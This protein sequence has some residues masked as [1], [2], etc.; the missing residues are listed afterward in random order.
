MSYTKRERE[1][2]EFAT[3]KLNENI[4]SLE[5]VR[6]TLEL[7]HNCASDVTGIVPTGKLLS[8]KLADT[9]TALEDVEVLFRKLREELEEALDG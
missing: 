1:L 3:A 6:T 9:L 5:S 4:V 8:D 2:I 7:I